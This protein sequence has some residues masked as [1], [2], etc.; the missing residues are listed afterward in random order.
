MGPYRSHHS[1]GR[2]HAAHRASLPKKLIHVDNFNGCAEMNG[3]RAAFGQ[4]GRGSIQRHARASVA[5][6]EHS[7]G[8]FMVAAAKRRRQKR[9]SIQ[10]CNRR[11]AD[12]V[13]AANRAQGLALAVPALRRR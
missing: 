11:R 10:A 3:A 6:L 2:E 7:K 4:P 9:P 13:A 8:A 5:A 12:I 1:G